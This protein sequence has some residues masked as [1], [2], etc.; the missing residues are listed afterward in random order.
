MGI[1]SGRV[2]EEDVAFGVLQIA[3]LAPDGIATFDRCRQ[4]LPHY[5]KLSTER[6]ASVGDTTKRGNVASANKEY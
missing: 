1:Q 4:R 6:S 2:T 5:L 3:V